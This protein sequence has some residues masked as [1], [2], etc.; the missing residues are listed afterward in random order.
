MD[1]EEE[2]EKARSNMKGK[3]GRWGQR[4]EYKKGQY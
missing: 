4:K 2:A 1:G 3:K